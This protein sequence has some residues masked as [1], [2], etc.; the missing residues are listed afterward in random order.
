MAE[1]QALAN[2]GLF[3]RDLALGWTIFA[4]L[5]TSQCPFQRIK[6]SVA[7]ASI[8][9]QPGAG[10]LGDVRNLRAEHG[11]GYFWRG[12]LTSVLRNG[13]VQGSALAF[14]DLYKRLLLSPATTTTVAAANDEDDDGAKRRRT[15]AATTPTSRFS[16]GR[17]SAHLLSGGMAGATTLLLFVPLDQARLMVA[18]PRSK[19]KFRGIADCLAKTV[20][21]RGVRQLYPPGTTVAVASAFVFRAGQLGL[22][23]S[24]MEYWNPY[25]DD[26][27]TK[28]LAS[29]VAV[30][31]AARTVTVLFTYPLDTV[32]RRMMLESD[33]P[34]EKRQFKSAL[35]CARKLVAQE[36][37]KRGLYQAFRPELFRG[38]GGIA[39]VV[40][41]DRLKVVLGMGQ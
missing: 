36:G 10:F 23:G 41:Y 9:L 28:G 31:V 25:K 7:E 32:R 1:Q 8:R 34:A 37:V 2:L 22:Y 5:Q 16:V 35:D 33:V 39:V 29:A 26:T 18:W 20:W 12:N 24:A 21:H 30:G 40:L 13:P 4:A 6:V 19:G 27:G 17:F 15:A 38:F 11:W 3:A 14:N